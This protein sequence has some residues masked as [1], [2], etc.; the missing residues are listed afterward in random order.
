M[1]EGC[2]PKRVQ[3]KHVIWEQTSP[4]T[5]SKS[6]IRTGATESLWPVELCVSNPMNCRVTGIAEMF[7]TFWTEFVLTLNSLK[8]QLSQTVSNQTP[9]FTRF[10]FYK[11]N[12]EITAVEAIVHLR[13][14]VYPVLPQKHQGS[15]F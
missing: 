6:Q 2:T 11:G 3:S 13:I 1:R 12:A 15:P 5:N 10:S 9:N 7:F 8:T 14:E 4:G